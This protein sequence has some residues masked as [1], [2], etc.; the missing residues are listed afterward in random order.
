[1][2]AEA[3]AMLLARHLGKAG[4]QALLEDLSRRALSE[5][6]QLL[7]LVEEAVAANATL[8]AKVSADELRA[9]FDA[10]AAARQ[11]S[12]VVRTQW[13]DLRARAAALDARPIQPVS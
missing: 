9:A 6:R 8:V 12:R 10:D 1:M 5:Q 2:S 11:A 4:A 13:A 3:A 7:A